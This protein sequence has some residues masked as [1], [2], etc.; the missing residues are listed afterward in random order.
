MAWQT[1]CLVFHLCYFSH[2]LPFFMVK[3]M[4]KCCPYEW[5]K[6]VQWN[7]GG[8]NYKSSIF[9][10]EDWIFLNGR[11]DKNGLR[12]VDAS[13]CLQ[14]LKTP[15]KTQFTSKV[16]LLKKTLKFKDV[17]NLNSNSLVKHDSYSLNMGC[18]I[19]LLEIIISMLIQCVLNQSWRFWLLSNAIFLLP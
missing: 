10:T 16:I 2:M 17:I 11:V 9:P 15:I 4:S 6:N 1:L 5:P 7:G 13:L 19:E 12:L 18:G 8:F 3:P 14:R